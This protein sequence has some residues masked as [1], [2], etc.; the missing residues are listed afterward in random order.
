[1]FLSLDAKKKADNFCIYLEWIVYESK[2]ITNLMKKYS[3]KCQNYFSKNHENSFDKFCLAETFKIYY[4]L[5]KKKIL[6][7]YQ[8]I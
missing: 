8:K 6:K 4:Y 2:A 3:E 1:M 5:K 7:K